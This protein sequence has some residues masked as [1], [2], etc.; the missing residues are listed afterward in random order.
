[1]YPFRKSCVNTLLLIYVEKVTI[2]KE[3]NA[4]LNE[5]YRSNAASKVYLV[6]SRHYP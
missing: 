3:I 6:Q 5:S 4:V 2:D 1:M